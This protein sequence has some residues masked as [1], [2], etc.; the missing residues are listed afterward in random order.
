MLQEG[1]RDGL[2]E[3]FWAMIAGALAATPSATE[4]LYH[5]YI[6]VPPVPLTPLHLVEVML[7]TVCVVVAV[8]VRVI[9]SKRSK[10]VSTL[11]EEIRARTANVSA[12]SSS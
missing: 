9:H 8:V 11:V 7:V 1:N 6:Y 10:R 4:A 3:A 12:P 2:S 5:A